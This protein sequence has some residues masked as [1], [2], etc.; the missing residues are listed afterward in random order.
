[1][2]TLNAQNA[3]ILHA[4]ERI[5]HVHGENPQG[6]RRNPQP[7]RKSPPVIGAASR[8]GR[9]CHGSVVILGNRDAVLSQNSPQQ[10]SSP[11]IK[12]QL[13]PHGIE[14]FQRLLFRFLEDH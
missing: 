9:Q 7:R 2:S 12:A 14:D 3:Q 13:L 4:P 5:H 11:H 10:L 1:M 6:R 8:G